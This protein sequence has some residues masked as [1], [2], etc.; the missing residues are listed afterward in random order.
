[1]R[2]F[3]DGWF[4]SEKPLANGASQDTRH[5]ITQHRIP[6]DRKR[7]RAKYICP[8]STLVQLIRMLCGQLLR[9]HLVA[10]LDWLTDALCGGRDAGCEYTYILQIYLMY[11]YGGML[12][13]KTYQNIC[14]AARGRAVFLGR[15]RWCKRAPDVRS[16]RTHNGIGKWAI[17]RTM[18]V[19]AK[20]WFGGRFVYMFCVVDVEETQSNRDEC[21][22]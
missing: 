4:R 1:M 9:S 6:A 13:N 11:I 7:E 15:L 21:V 16:K 3:F 12:C 14:C 18:W 22:F 10:R 8:Q 17:P 19:E 2:F 20:G 5:S